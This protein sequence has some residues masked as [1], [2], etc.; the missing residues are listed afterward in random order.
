MTNVRRRSTSVLLGLLVALASVLGIACL[1]THGH[2]AL[3]VAAASTTPAAPTSYDIATDDT[4]ERVCASPGHDRCGGSAA[5]GNPTTGPGPHPVPQAL[6]VRVDA[7][8]VAL[9]VPA[10][11]RPA[12]PRPP[13]L[14][15]LQVLRT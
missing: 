14:H 2:V 4:R 8:P 5:V 1:C 3:P 10:D 6:P 9:P 13:D 7:R 12:A 11:A 15:T